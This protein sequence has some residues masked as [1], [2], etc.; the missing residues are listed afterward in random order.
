[1]CHE[2]TFVELRK[3]MHVV[4]TCEEKVGSSVIIPAGG[5]F[6]EHVEFDLNT[7]CISYRFY[8]GRFADLGLVGFDCLCRNARLPICPHK[9]LDLLADYLLR[10]TSPVIAVGA[11]TVR[12]NSI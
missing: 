5:C 3:L 4:D 7:M 6:S 1:M 2:M 8:L 11:L 10:Y 9:K 12:Q